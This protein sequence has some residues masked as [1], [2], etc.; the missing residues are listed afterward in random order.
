[1]VHNRTAEKLKVFISYSR[2]DSSD[3][4]EELVAV[5]ELA[6]FAPFL[7]RHDIA[8]GEDWEARLGGL[9]REA[10]TIVFV[11][12][13][14]AVK[15]DRCAWEVN[16]ALAQSK[17]VLP[18]I[19]KPAPEAEIPEPLRRR[20]FIRFDAG[21]GIARPL[22]Q[23]AEALS[24]DIDWIREHT[25]LGELARRWEMRG[26]SESLLLRG[27][28][29]L[30]AEAW[31]GRWHAGAPEITDSM[32]SFLAASKQ[33]EAA[34]VAKSKAERRRTIRM[35]ALVLLLLVGM[36]AS[37]VGWVNQSYIGAEWRWY[38]FVRPFAAANFWPYVLTLATERALNPKDTFKECKPEPGKSYCPQ[39][40]VIPS[41]SFTMGAPPDESGEDA[42]ARPHHIVTI[43]KPFA[44]STYQVT[45]DEWGTCV[46][47]GDCAPKDDNGWG[48]GTRPVIFVT[49]KDA[50]TY[51]VWLS[52]MTG[53]S[54]RL[55]S[56]AEYEYVMRAGSQAA[57]P[58]GDQ[59][60]KNNADCDGCG[61]QWD[62]KQTAPV[63]S[64]APNRFGL[65][66]MTGNVWEWVE[67]CLHTDYGGAPNDG[68]AWTKDGIC[69]TRIQRG[70][71]YDSPIPLLRSFFRNWN[72][73][74]NAD[75][76]F[77]FRVTRTLS[78]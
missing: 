61:S 27:D 68:S 16:N 70:G 8:A 69:G 42:S 31:S 9:I 59:I 44:V 30:A 63:G 24:Q 77:G 45:F 7:D 48:S 37:V 2:R 33:S 67:D 58:W 40:T 56:E 73:T 60:E 26:R 47:Y 3:F 11:V 25:R 52:K 39:M 41:G 18:V 64:F 6:G 72:A 13:P 4:A 49:W 57:Y 76:D 43:A 34:H 19:F 15:S 54:Y 21:P 32:R 75:K 23:L 66:D 22:G 65:H 71:G 74:D 1:M 51:V 36:T 14:E 55:L 50:E 35:Q 38:S 20:Q 28:D 12:S 62:D 29:L 5:L 10:D 17:R 46:A 53:K 78:P